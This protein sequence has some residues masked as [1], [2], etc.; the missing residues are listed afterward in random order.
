M[1]SS[2]SSSQSG[3]DQLL[4]RN[5]GFYDEL[6]SGSRLV[7]PERF[8]AWARVAELVGECP[9]RLEVGAGMRPRLPI[10]GSYFADISAPA[11]QSLREAGGR[12]ARAQVQY[13][14][15]AE[16][17]FDLVA[18][19]DVLEHVKDDDRA[20]GELKRVLRPG[21]R[22]L[23]S[24]PL[25]QANWTPFDEIV[26][27]Y[28]RYEPAQLGALFERF[29]IRVLESAAYGMKPKSSRLVGLGMRM[30]A[31]MPERAMWWYNNVL[32]PIGVRMQ[33]PLRFESR[34]IDD[35]E[36]DAII[37]VAERI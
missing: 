20:L 5:R 31:E 35:L 8:N 11:L 7:R 25:H 36:A 18:A 34:L 22:L 2:P 17:A 26:G 33:K 4:E 23:L 10:G 16:G 27:H 37:V 13:L 9:S 30:L 14:P 3:A 12:A 24:F 29:G 19:L 28:R 6:W 32:T 21:G 15:F 1:I